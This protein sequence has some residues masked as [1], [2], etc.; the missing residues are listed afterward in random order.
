MT[1]EMHEYNRRF[2]ADKACV[3]FITSK[4]TEK[5][6]AILSG[7]IMDSVTQQLNTIES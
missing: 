5:G 7:Y 1:N 4:Y 6:I 3:R 2:V